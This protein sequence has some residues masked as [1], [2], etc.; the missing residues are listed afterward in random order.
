MSNFTQ[1]TLP[2]VRLLLNIQT[3]DVEDCWNEGYR[4]FAKNKNEDD[5]PYMADSI[6]RE[7]W[8]NG[9]WDAFSSISTTPQKSQCL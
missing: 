1:N 7:A 8:K 2:Y 3:P 5:S 6:E 4:S 9:W